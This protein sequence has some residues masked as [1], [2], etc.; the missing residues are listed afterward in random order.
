MLPVQQVVQEGL[1]ALRVSGNREI[2]PENPKTRGL[3]KMVDSPVRADPFYLSF[4]KDPLLR[5]LKQLEFQGG[6][7]CVAD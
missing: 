1:D 2:F 5:H 3:G 6:A 7:P 4:C